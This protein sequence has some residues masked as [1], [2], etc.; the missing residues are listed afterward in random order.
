MLRTKGGPPRN[1]VTGDTDILRK[2]ICKLLFSSVHVTRVMKLRIKCVTHMEK[3]T[4]IFC[5]ESGRVSVHL[6]SC[7]E[8][9]EQVLSGGGDYRGQRYQG[10]RQIQ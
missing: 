7:V 9:T 4:Q 1:E 2:E 8:V 10:F 5:R 3:C 6:H